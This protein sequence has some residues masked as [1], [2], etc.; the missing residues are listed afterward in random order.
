MRFIYIFL[1]MLFLH[2]VPVVQAAPIETY[3][4]ETPEQEEIFYKLNDELRCLV[5]QNQNI[6]ESN[7][8]LAKDLRREIY[9]MINEGQ[10]E[11]QIVDFMVQRYGD[12][13][14]YRPPFKPLTW[15]LWFGP[16]V[17]FFI[18]L[19]IVIRLVKAQSEDKK[20]L[21]FSEEEV[22]RIKNL[23]SEHNRPDVSSSEP[24]GKETGS[25]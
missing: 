10:T 3:T 5:C 17:I 8:D 11:D 25:K 1:T 19:F 16:A 23:Y 22:E 20:V 6:A 12:Y 13:V 24:D 2:L 21:S 14:L 4:F 18:G 9:K 7:A 15:L